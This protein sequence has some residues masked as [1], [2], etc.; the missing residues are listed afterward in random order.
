MDIDG[1]S[2][3]IGDGS[4]AT[5]R[6]ASRGLVSCGEQGKGEGKAKSQRGEANPEITPYQRYRRR[7]SAVAR[8]LSF[9]CR[10]CIPVPVSLSFST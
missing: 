1:N 7:E 8:Q 2:A 3:M 5:H 10:Y 6:I 9:L 4:Q